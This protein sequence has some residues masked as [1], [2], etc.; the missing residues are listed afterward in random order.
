[1]SSP[2]RGFVSF[3]LLSAI[4][5]GAVLGLVWAVILREVEARQLS[6]EFEALRMAAGLAEAFMED[7]GFSELGEAVLGFGLYSSSGEALVRRGSAPA[8]F[9]SEGTELPIVEKGRGGAS[10]IMVRPIGAGSLRAGGMMRGRMRRGMMMSSPLEAPPPVGTGSGTELG[11]RAGPGGLAPGAGPSQGGLQGGPALSPANQA[12]QPR[13]AQV[14]WL[15]YGLR[16]ALRREEASLYGVALAVSALLAALYVLL[17]LLYRRNAELREREVRNRELVEL[18]GAA[19]TLVHEMKNPLA[20]IRIQTAALRRQVPAE[21][22]A[23]VAPASKIIDEEVERLSSLSDRIREYLRSGEGRPEELD[24]SSFLRDYAARYRGEEGGADGF[25]LGPLP[26]RARVRIDPARLGEVLDNLILNAKEAGPSERPS[27]ELSQRGKRL[28]LEV[29]DRG[30]G[31]A[32][33]IAERIFEPFFTTKERGTGI[34]LALSRRVV[35]SAGGS[36]SYK[37]RPGGGSIFTVSLP[38]LD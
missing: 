7:P 16:P 11:P 4:A 1:M 37:A 5:L 9:S 8:S 25:D 2:R 19:R 30:K 15:E 17:L 3:V 36:L 32:P 21:A 18:G 10:V 38:A 24:L 20:V 22:L 29:L 13:A 35:E 28:E 27:V 23:R 33:E 26:D 34:G 14:A 31:V 6:E 12:V